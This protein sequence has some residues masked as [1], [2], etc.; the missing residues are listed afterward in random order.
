MCLVTAITAVGLCSFLEMR[1]QLVLPCLA[2]LL[3]SEV[4]G[5]GWVR[6]AETLWGQTTSEER[7]RLVGKSIDLTFKSEVKIS[8]YHTLP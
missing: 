8:Q 7:E 2:S 1:E 5:L 4:Q 3:P 6:I